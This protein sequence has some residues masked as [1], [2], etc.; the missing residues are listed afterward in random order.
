MRDWRHTIE[1]LERKADDRAVTEH[2]RAALL[3][4]AAELRERHGITAEPS[5]EE[6]LAAM[7]AAAQRAASSQPYFTVVQNGGTIRVTVNFGP[8]GG[9]YGGTT[10]STFNR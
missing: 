4:K 5:Y 3:S 8:T 10:S 9:W 2:E 1:S 7:R 6:Q